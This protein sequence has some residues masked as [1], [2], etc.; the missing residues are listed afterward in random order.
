[1]SEA[2]RDH[3]KAIVVADRGWVWVGNVSS[4]PDFTTIAGAQCVRRW[5]TS[6]GLAELA[7]KGPRPNT[8]LD[9]P[10]EIRV[11]SRAVIAILPCEAAAWS[12]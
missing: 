12:A 4:G 11:A 10:T 2:S 3:G 1:M 8:R 9:P 7:Q 6:E 5:G